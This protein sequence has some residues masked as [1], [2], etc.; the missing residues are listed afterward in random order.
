KLEWK[1]EKDKP[2]YQTV[3]TET[4]REVKPVE[5]DAK[6]QGS[7]PDGAKPEGSKPDGAKPD[8]AK[9]DSSKP[10]PAKPDSKQIFYLSWTPIKQ[11]DKNWILKMKIEG[12]NVQFS[13]GDAKDTKIAFDS[14]SDQKPSGVLPLF[15]SKLVGAELTYTLNSELQAIKVEGRD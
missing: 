7:K 4:V 11:E 15:Y 14:T 12:V 2:F 3:A 6:P 1:F 5:K 9:P 8:S 13:T 10:E